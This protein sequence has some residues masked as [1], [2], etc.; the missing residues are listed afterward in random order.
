[1]PSRFWGSLLALLIVAWTLGLSWYQFGSA[2]IKPD[3]IN[4]AWSDGALTVV[5]VTPRGAAARAGI[6]D[7]DRIFMRGYADAYRLLYVT[8]DGRPLTFDVESRSS[9]RRAVTL[10][11]NHPS[12]LLVTVSE[13]VVKVVLFNAV[14]LLGA[15]LMWRRPSVM[16]AAFALYVTFGPY[17]RADPMSLV[18]GAPN[19]V[20]GPLAILIDVLLSVVP[21]AALLPFLARFPNP[22]KRSQTLIRAADVAFG[23]ICAATLIVTVASRNNVVGARSGQDVIAVITASL[24]A[25]CACLT[26]L[27]ARGEDRVRTGWVPV[28]LA[29]TAT[30]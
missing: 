13:S 11:F 15:L 7:G 18:S 17:N 24:I 23:V 9:A 12:T 27:Y 25:I 29:I 28:G 5:G 30:A 20:F 6:S 19:A 4:T 26:L 8:F 22:A 10:R 16:T 2:R 21:I 14:T 3:R 1:M